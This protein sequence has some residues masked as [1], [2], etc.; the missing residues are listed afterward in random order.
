M[1]RWSK[2]IHYKK[3][4]ILLTNYLNL[5]FSIVKLKYKKYDQKLFGENFHINLWTCQISI[6]N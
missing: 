4:H 6:D 5:G 1:K 2:K 3:I